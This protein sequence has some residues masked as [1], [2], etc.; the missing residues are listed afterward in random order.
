MRYK[1]AI[2]IKKCKN[3]EYCYKSQFNRVVDR[4]D[5]ASAAE[6]I[7]LSSIFHLVKH[8]TFIFVFT[9]FCLTTILDGRQTAACL[10]TCKVA[11]MSPGL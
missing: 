11:T 7:D 8:L 10:E 5:R 1:K 3:Q 9:V 6:A 2:K 4:V